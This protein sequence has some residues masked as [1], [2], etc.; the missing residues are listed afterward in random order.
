MFSHIYVSFTDKEEPR[1]KNR[2]R[3]ILY[4]TDYE[5]VTNNWVIQKNNLIFLCMLLR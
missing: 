1:H 5:R 3:K 2:E 4:I